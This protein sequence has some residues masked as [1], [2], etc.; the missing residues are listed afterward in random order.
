ITLLCVFVAVA[1]IGA[2]LH[3]QPVTLARTNQTTLLNNQL[4]IVPLRNLADRQTALITRLD[5]QLSDTFVHE[6]S[7]YAPVDHFAIP[8]LPDGY[9]KLDEEIK[10]YNT[11]I[12]ALTAED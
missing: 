12:A 10:F 9:P 7:R 11:I 3:A 4:H 5:D 6:L 8:N 2:A 1:Y